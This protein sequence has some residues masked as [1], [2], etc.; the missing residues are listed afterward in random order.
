VPF[1]AVYQTGHLPF[2]DENT[3]NLIS[4]KTSEMLLTNVSRRAQG[5]GGIFCARASIRQ[6][7]FLQA[8]A[9]L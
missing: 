3:F 8:S 1:A 2:W 5:A 9:T 6:M 4:P 7:T